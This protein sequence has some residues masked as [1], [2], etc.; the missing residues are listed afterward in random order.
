MIKLLCKNNICNTNN[1]Y[2]WLYRQSLSQGVSAIIGDNLLRN[3]TEVSYSA[4]SQIPKILKIQWYLAIENAIK[5]YNYRRRL[6]K[7]IADIWAKEGIKT[8]C[9]KGWALSTYYPN[10]KL[11][12]CG[13]FDCWLGGNFER[14]NQIAIANG[15]KFNPHDYRHS[16]IYYNGLTIENHRYF[17]PIRGNPRKKRLE[18]YLQS[19]IHSDKRIENSNVYYPSPQFHSL[20]LV[21]HML[22]HFLYENI[23]L[24]HMLDW[25]YF[26]NTEKDNVDWCEFSMKCEEAGGTRFIEAINYICV[27]HLGLNIN[28]TKLIANNRYAERILQDTLKQSSNRVSGMSNLLTQRYLKVKNIIAQQWKFNEVYDTNFITSIIQSI[29]GIIFDRKVRF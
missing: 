6:S 27:E 12:E 23:T 4:K 2:Q 18:R 13:D 22:Q 26:V 29:Q 10:P 14:G 9:L 24:R 1:E 17:L 11:R 7:E 25:A 21:M 15:A 19:V 20:F 8:Y 5:Q 16:L 28:D 3:T